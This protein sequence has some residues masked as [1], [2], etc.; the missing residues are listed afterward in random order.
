MK[1]KNVGLSLVEAG[2]LASALANFRKELSLFESLS[3]AD[4][5]DV[6]GRRNRSLALAD[7]D[8]AAYRILA[9][10]PGRYGRG[11]CWGDRGAGSQADW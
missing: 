8:A 9:G 10:D 2:D 11:G 5:K 1:S 4:P 6:Q 3:A 7:E